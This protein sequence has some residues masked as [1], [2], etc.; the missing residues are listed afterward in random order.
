MYINIYMLFF[1]CYACLPNFP[2]LNT[3]RERQAWPPM[4]SQI[5]V[6]NNTFL[7]PFK[8]DPYAP[9]DSGIQLP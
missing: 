5:G 8:Y 6:S 4:E 9:E 1:K 2:N 3:R 7:G